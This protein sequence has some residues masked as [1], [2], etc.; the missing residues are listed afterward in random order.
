MPGN[1]PWSRVEQEDSRICFFVGVAGGK[2]HAFA[3]TKLHL[4]RRKVRDQH[5]QP[6]DQIFRFV[7]RLDPGKDDPLAAFTGVERQLEQLV[8]AVDDSM[9][10]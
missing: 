8:A 9:P 10:R 2:H 6:T 3:D 4:A 7:G 1:A 5:G